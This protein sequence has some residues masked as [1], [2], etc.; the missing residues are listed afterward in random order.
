[1]I[2]KEKSS[3]STAWVK[4]EGNCQKPYRQSSLSVCGRVDCKRGY[5]FYI[6]VWVD[7]FNQRAAVEGSAGCTFDSVC[8]TE[9]NIV[10]WA[11][12]IE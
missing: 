5:Y 10:A 8:S 12:L 9:I 4:V 6:Q 7:P 1:M 3:I 11:M 2:W